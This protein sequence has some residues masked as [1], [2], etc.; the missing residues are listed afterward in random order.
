MLGYFRSTTTIQVMLYLFSNFCRCCASTT[1]IQVM[2]YL[3]SNF[4]RYY[5]STTAINQ[6]L[7]RLDI[8]NCLVLRPFWWDTVSIYE[9]WGNTCY[10][11]KSLKWSTI[12]LLYNA[13]AL[14]S[15]EILGSILEWSFFE[16]MLKRVTHC[17]NSC[18]STLIQL[19]VVLWR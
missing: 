12:I 7:N 2:S 19:C 8:S 3:F 1:A 11:F 4:C 14:I 13:K 9:M 18:G 5:A 15:F 16:S 6:P 10:S 17:W